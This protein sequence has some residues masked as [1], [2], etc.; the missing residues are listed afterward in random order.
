MLA[1]T[2]GV[3]CLMRARIAAKTVVAPH[4]AFPLRSPSGFPQTLMHPRRDRGAVL[5]L[6]Y[7]PVPRLADEYNAAQ[8]RGEVA[9]GS[10]GRG[11]NIVADHNDIKPATV[12]DL[13]IR[14]DEIHDARKMRDAEKTLKPVAEGEPDCRVVGYP[15]QWR[16][17]W[18]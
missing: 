2:I 10:T 8:D 7:Q 15:V 17:V 13:G 1:L 18:C 5:R 14:R 3:V 6:L 11:D 9:K 16:S 12:A 4:Q